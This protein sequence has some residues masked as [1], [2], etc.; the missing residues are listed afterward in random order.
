MER[1]AVCWAETFY[2]IVQNNLCHQKKAEN[3]RANMREFLP[4]TQKHYHIDAT[5][6][7]SQRKTDEP[8]FVVACSSGRKRASGKD[9]KKNTSSEQKR[10]IRGMS[11]KQ[12]C[13]PRLEP[14]PC[15]SRHTKET[16]GADLRNFFASVPHESH[17]AHRAT[18]SASTNPDGGSR[19][20]YRRTR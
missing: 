18:L 7:V 6:S 17:I 4:W 13:T 2:E 10:K 16:Y 8:S 1:T 20:T 11:L 15:S 9:S 5:T 19:T 14:D 3:V 12:R